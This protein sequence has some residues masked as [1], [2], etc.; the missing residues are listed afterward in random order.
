MDLWT[1]LS[2][3]LVDSSLIY[4]RVC[5]E[6]GKECV[7]SQWENPDHSWPL[8]FANKQSDKANRARGCYLVM[9]RHKV[10][11]LNGRMTISQREF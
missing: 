2:I 4:S 11:K 3:L 5:G 10:G 9:F 8:K 7:Y 1:A 6:G